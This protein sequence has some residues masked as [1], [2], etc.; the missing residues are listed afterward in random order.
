MK[1]IEGSLLDVL[2]E[3]KRIIIEEKEV[4]HTHPLSS[5]LKPNETVYKTVVLST[6]PQAYIDLDSLDLI[7]QAISVHEKFQQN[8]QTPQWPQRILEDFAL[9]DYDLIMSTLPRLLYA[10]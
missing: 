10:N 9:I 4:I 7:E 2:E 1:Y 5:S 8:F 3:V 6:K